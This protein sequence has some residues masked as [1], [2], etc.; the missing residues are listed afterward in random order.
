MIPQRQL[1]QY[2]LKVSAIGYGAMVAEGVYGA[3]DEAAAIAT[4]HHALDL[5]VN[6]IDTADF[7]GSGHNEILVGKVLKE[8]RKDCVLATKF[9]IVFDPNETGTEWPMNF[10][11]TLRMNGKPAYLRKCLDDSLKRLRVDTI[12][13]WYLHWPDFETP[14]EDTVGAMAEAVQAGK[15]H[16]LG[17]SNPTAELVRR[18]HKVHPIAAVQYEYSLWRR[19]METR[20]VPT[21]KELGIGLVPWSP[22]GNGFLTGTVHDLPEDDF[23]NSNRKFAGANLKTNADRFAPIAAIAKELGITPAQLALAWLLHQGPDVVPIPGTRRKERV[24]ENAAAAS[25]R[26]SAD[27]LKRI[28]QLCPVGAFKGEALI[29]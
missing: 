3:V 19:E 8:R 27:V 22:L 29:D 15:V 16:H 11:F 9:G 12:D 13:L 5:G 18:A 4:M 21:L 1:G 2:D 25:V 26:L 24:S 14:I 10:G 20:L 17:L 28:D 7:Y 23:R 6:F